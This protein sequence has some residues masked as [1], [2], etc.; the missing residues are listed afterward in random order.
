MKKKLNQVNLLSPS[1]I[2][3]IGED[4]CTALFQKNMTKKQFAALSSIGFMII[5]DTLYDK[6]SKKLIVKRLGELHA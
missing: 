1:V 2:K 6:K 3:E 5:L 4:F